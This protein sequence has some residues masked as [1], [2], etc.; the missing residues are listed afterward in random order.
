[1]DF[2]DTRAAKIS[3]L[4]FMAQHIPGDVHVHTAYSKRTKHRVDLQ[5]DA[6]R[7]ASTTDAS[8]QRLSKAAAL[9]A[10]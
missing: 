1:M 6:T 5:R 7:R 10:Y 4:S 2:I 9:R 3:A 8:L